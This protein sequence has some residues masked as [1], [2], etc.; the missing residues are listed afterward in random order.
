[1]LLLLSQDSTTISALLIIL[2]SAKARHVFGLD[3][4]VF[5]EVSTGVILICSL[6]KHD[7]FSA[8]AL[9]SFSDAVV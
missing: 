9:I 6:I 7:E 3:L 4:N 2:E 5:I 8:Y 1:M